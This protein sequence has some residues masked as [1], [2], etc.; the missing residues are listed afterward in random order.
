[1]LKMSDDPSYPKNLTPNAIKHIHDC[2][3]ETLP[4]LFDLILQ[5]IK[6]EEV[7]QNPEKK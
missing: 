2:N 5:V 3:K 1:M 7:Q 6:V 4:K